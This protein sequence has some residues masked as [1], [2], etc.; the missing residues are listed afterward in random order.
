MFSHDI[1]DCPGK[2]LP[3]FLPFVLVLFKQV[4]IWLENRQSMHWCP[5]DLTCLHRYY[6][7]VLKERNPFPG[8]RPFPPL[9]PDHDRL[10]GFQGSE[11]AFFES[12]QMCAICL[13]A[14]GEATNLGVSG[15]SF[16]LFLPG[17]YCF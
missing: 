8:R 11:S 6:D 3:L 12:S 5:K 17:F 4:V 7:R 1:P 14:L 15:V 13:G 16:H 2:D 9:V 10:H